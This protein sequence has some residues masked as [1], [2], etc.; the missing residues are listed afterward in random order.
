[1]KQ[2][3]E[4]EYKT[5]ITERDY[6]RL[7]ESLSFEKGK[8]Q[9]NYYYDTEDMRL[10]KQGIMCRIR[11]VSNTFLFTVK[12]PQEVGVLEFEVNLDT[13]SLDHEAIIAYFEA[14]NI[15][16]AAL[17]IVAWSDTLRS[18]YAD[19]YGEWCLDFSTFEHHTDYE[20]EYELY[21][22]HEKA[23]SHYEKMLQEFQLDFKAIQPKY[24]RALHSGK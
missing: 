12:V 2:H 21:E 14:L 23:P 17:Q 19:T 20:L 16:I 4:I 1:M 11:N 7:L 22:Y 24:L 5:E 3:L 13:L 6:E 8:Q 10:F 18:I 15:S 9:K